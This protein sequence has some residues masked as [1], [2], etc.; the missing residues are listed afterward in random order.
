MHLTEYYE[1]I[2]MVIFADYWKISM[3]SS[4][5]KYDTWLYDQHTYKLIES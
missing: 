5:L 1:A 3:L 2:K 4:L